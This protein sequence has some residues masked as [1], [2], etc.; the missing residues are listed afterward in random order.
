M[1]SRTKMLCAFTVLLF[2]GSLATGSVSASYVL[3]G[4][5]NNEQLISA[6][7]YGDDR[8]NKA[9]NILIYTE[10]TDLDPGQEWDNTMSSM[11][12]S[13]EGKFTYDNLTD[14]TQLGSII[15]E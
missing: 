2:I 12:G 13:L 11:I 9:V 14:Y 4:T 5:V 3:S 6:D 10:F 15:E 8:R 7:T 1:N